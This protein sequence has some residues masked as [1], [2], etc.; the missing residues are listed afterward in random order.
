MNRGLFTS[1]TCEWATPQ[2]VFDALD[3]EFGFTLDVCA[4]AANAKCPRYFDA[5]ANGLQQPWAPDVSWLNP[6]YGRTIGHWTDKAAKEAR[7]G[8]TVV[9]LVPA[10]VDTKWFKRAFDTAAEVRFIQGRLKFGDAVASAPFPSCVLV[11]RP[12]VKT[13]TGP[14]VSYWTAAETH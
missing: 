4:T 1:S 5:T 3:A 14:G 11:F 6:P 10:R 13:T 9:C 8:A 7:A 2:Y 12:G